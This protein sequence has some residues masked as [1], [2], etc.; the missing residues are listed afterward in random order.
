MG[1]GDISVSAGGTPIPTA[2]TVAEFDEDAHINSEDMSS[3]DVEDFLAD[4]NAQGTPSE[5]KKLL[6]S[7]ANPTSA[8]SG[9]TTIVASGADEYDAIEVIY[10]TA[11]IYD[12]YETALSPFVA[13]AHITLL[14]P[15]GTGGEFSGAIY[16]AVRTISMGAGGVLM[17]DQA[18]GMN[19]TTTVTNNNMCIPYRVYGIKYEKVAPIQV[20]EQWVQVGAA[21]AQGNLT[22]TKKISD[23]R[24]IAWYLIENQYGAVEGFFYTPVSVFV[25]YNNT[26]HSMGINAYNGGRQYA[27]LNYVNDTTVNVQL[28]GSRSVAVW[29]IS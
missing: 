28:S 1:S 26:A 5:Y 16:N 9:G 17:V 11:H 7:N 24:Y 25:Q 23:Y 19:S 21:S 18:V 6:W 8:M 10:K 15:S 12:G 3:Q 20:D 13:G 22:L 4:I 29:L 2:D 14:A 27:Y